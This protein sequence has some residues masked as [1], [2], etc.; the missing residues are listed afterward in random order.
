MFLPRCS[1]IVIGCAPRA[2]FDEVPDE[3]QHVEGLTCRRTNR[4]GRGVLCL[5]DPL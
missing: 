5:G 3:W 1:S 2:M 4:G